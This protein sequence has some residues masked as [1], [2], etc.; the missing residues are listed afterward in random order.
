MAEKGTGPVYIFPLGLLYIS[1]NLPKQ[2]L[3]MQLKKKLQNPKSLKMM[4]KASNC[5]NYNGRFLM[6][7]KL[8]LCTDQQQSHPR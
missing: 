3:L 4:F 1:V 2:T 8:S 7:E 5:R 6:E